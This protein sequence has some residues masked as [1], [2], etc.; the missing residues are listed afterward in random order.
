MILCLG[1]WANALTP[2]MDF[3]D[4]NLVVGDVHWVLERIASQAK[5]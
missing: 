3:T 5:N 1:W 4:F 2:D